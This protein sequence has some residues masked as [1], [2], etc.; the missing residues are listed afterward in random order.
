MNKQTPKITGFA[1]FDTLLNYV[2]GL[3][4]EGKDKSRG[5][6]YQLIPLDRG[7]LEAAYRADWVARKIIDCPPQDS[8]REWRAWQAKNA[9]I[10]KIEAVEQL[11]AIQY[12]VKRAMQYAR[13][14]GGGVMIMGIKQTTPQELLDVD[15]IKQGDLEFVHVVPRHRVTVH[16]IDT[17]LLSPFFGE[18]KWY[19]VSSKIGVP[20][21]IHPSRV[22]R[23]LGAEYPDEETAGDV[24]WSDSVLQAVDDAVKNAARTAASL[25]AMID[26]LKVDV[27]KI[28]GLMD[29][30]GT[31]EYK[32]L[33]TARVSSAMYLKSLWNTF[34]IDGT[35]ELEQKTAHLTGIPEVINTY[36]QIAS[37]AA[38][39][40][41]TRLLGQSP[42]GMNATGESDI[43]NY[44]DRLSSDQNNDLSPRLNRLDE[45]LLRA[46]TGSRD[47]NIH[48]I[49][50]PLWQMSEPE[51]ADV[52]LKK[53]QTFQIDVQS[54]VLDPDA[55]KTGR[56]NQLVE[57]GT[58]PGYED[59]LKEIE[60]EGV[61]E[62]DPEAV[63]AF[64]AAKGKPNPDGSLPGPA[65]TGSEIQKQ[66]L[67]GT[68]VSSLQEI[69]TAV[70][71]EQMP[72]ETAVAMIAVAF[73]M[74]SEADIKKI[75]DPLETFERKEPEPP[76]IVQPG[77]PN[78]PK[79][80]NQ[81][82]PVRRP[83]E[84]AV[85]DE[86]VEATDA[87]PRTLYVRRDVVNSG[88]IMNWAK[89]QGFDT[90]VPGSEMHVTIAYSK[91]PVD[92]MKVREGF[93]QND[94]GQV[95]IAPG[96]ARIVEPLGD[97]GAIV[98]MFSSRT[99]SWRNQDIIDCGA[100]W[101]YDDYQPH[102]TLTYKA[103]PEMIAKVN[104][105]LVEPYR[106]KI[107]LGPEIFE[108]VK[109]KAPIIEEK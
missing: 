10:E 29:N 65:G 21:K 63:A 2:T 82:T 102:I 76:V 89:A 71:E 41:V 70:V 17:D 59:A 81:N 93:D 77:N 24:G 46:A 18:P 38:D 48:Y 99:L 37:G 5:N 13:L 73:P 64:E 72:P 56:N 75:I 27:L 9:Q 69:V 95:T 23:F 44:Y 74:L 47:K 36:L 8:T 54:M 83:F 45:V 51:K 107:V 20:V 86:R 94:K 22:I 68:Q 92:W 1:A 16:E 97:Q 57:D 105:H 52:A 31:D 79:P 4:V 25:G 30:I 87:D 90:T 67:N 28:P 14:Y 80:A 50:N 96:G 12:K 40:P 60:D 61:D 33:L 26:E 35:E 78:A 109:V 98:L 15:K 11:F 42:A 6:Q 39:I 49:W 53:A 84:K 34:V 101:D 43:R 108:E 7:Q 100:S 58:Y 103:S 62:N 106:G 85:G 55:L 32:T 19:E 88:A 91:T 66:A 3:G 104:N